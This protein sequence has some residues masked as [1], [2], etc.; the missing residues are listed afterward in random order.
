MVAAAAAAAAAAMAAPGAHV[1][2]GAA[3]PQSPSPSS[4]LPSWGL[5]TCRAEA[6]RWLWGGVCASSPSREL[7]EVHEPVHWASSKRNKHQ[8][9]KSRGSH[10]IL[11]LFSLISLGKNV[12]SSAKA[13]PTSNVATAGCCP[14]ARCPYRGTGALGLLV[15]THPYGLPGLG[16]HP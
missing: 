13:R 10:K 7:S 6:D 8:R 2:E 11:G 16:C 12:S 5:A 14:A 9:L 1:S 15:T 4:S 3:P